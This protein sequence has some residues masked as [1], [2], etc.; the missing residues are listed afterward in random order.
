MKRVRFYVLG[1]SMSRTLLT[2]IRNDQRRGLKTKR[3]NNA[4]LWSHLRTWLP[5]VQTLCSRPSL[6]VQWLEV[7]PESHLLHLGW[8]FHVRHRPLPGCQHV[9]GVRFPPPP[10]SSIFSWRTQETP[11]LIGCGIQWRFL[12]LCSMRVLILESIPMRLL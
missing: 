5:I 9:E 11:S 10:V 1:S 4:F 3:I 8:V 2:A 12:D 7:I 6:G